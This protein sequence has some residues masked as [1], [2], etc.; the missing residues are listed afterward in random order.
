M[1]SYLG[2]AANQV[3]RKHIRKFHKLCESLGILQDEIRA[4]LPDSEYYVA[5]GNIHLMTG[6]S[7]TGS[8]GI[9]HQERVAATS[10]IG[11]IDGG[12]W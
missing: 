3:N 9:P 11:W 12:D 1:N 6:D 2:L 8:Q 4:Y 5:N 10:C 7:H